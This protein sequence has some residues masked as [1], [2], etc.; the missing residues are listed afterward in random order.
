[1]WPLTDKLEQKINRY[2]CDKPH[3][4]FQGFRLSDTSVQFLRVGRKNN[5]R[6]NSS[7][8]FLYEE[9]ISVSIHMHLYYEKKKNH[10]IL[11]LL[12]SSEYEQKLVLTVY[13]WCKIT[14]SL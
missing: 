3:Q 13:E 14:T 12:T 7:N 9:H 4:L 2:K 8:L 10:R 5:K 6:I 11:S 1:M